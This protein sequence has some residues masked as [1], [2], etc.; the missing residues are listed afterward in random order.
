MNFE[1]KLRDIFKHKFTLT[2]SKKAIAQTERNE[3]K[4]ELSDVIKDALEDASGDMDLIITR[5]I[6]GYIM[7]V[8]NEYLGM[9]PI[10]FVVKVRGIDY[11]I[12]E[13]EQEYI[14]KN[15]D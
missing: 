11:D 4:Y 7:E 2:A 9:I 6:D 8:E 10:E 12:Y 1:D 3:L 13:A 14:A 5:T 15:K